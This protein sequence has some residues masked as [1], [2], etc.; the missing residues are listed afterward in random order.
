M[1]AG[2]SGSRSCT[3]HKIWCC[4]LGHWPTV[5]ANSDGKL[6]RLGFLP[7]ARHPEVTAD[8]GRRPH[9]PS[10]KPTMS[11]SRHVSLPGGNRV[12]GVRLSET[13]TVRAKRPAPSVEGHI[14]RVLPGVNTLFS[15]KL[16]GDD[17][18]R[19]GIGAAAA[20]AVSRDHAHRPDS[21]AD[22]PLL[23]RAQVRCSMSRA[24]NCWDN[25]PVESFFRS[26]T[27]E[28]LGSPPWPTRAVAARAVH[29]DIERFYNTTRLHLRLGDQSPARFEQ[30]A[31]RRVSCH[32]PLK[33]IKITGL[34]SGFVRDEP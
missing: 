29:D 1:E 21:D 19:P 6:E 18:A 2:I 7:I 5:E 27:V 23:A 3:I 17:K 11:K 20:A 25:A 13:R 10:S 28:L 24:G 8:R 16:H 4:V 14:W 26:L 34:G 12:T 15:Q 33:R 22:Q 9:V 32:R 31:A 30:E